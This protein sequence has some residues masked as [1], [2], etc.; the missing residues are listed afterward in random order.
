[1]ENVIAA[2]E[3]ASVLFKCTVIIGIG[4]YTLNSYRNYRI[5]S[6]EQKASNR[7]LLRK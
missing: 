4:L 3:L 6:F 7:L 1:M 2:I 5:R